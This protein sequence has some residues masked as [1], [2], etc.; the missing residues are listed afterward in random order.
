MTLLITRGRARLDVLVETQNIVGIVFFLD[1]NK[2]SIIRAVGRADKSLA[3]F[4][5]L[6]AVGSLRKGLQL[7]AQ[8]LDPLHRTFFFGWSAPAAHE[9]QFV[10]RLPQ[11]KRS[12]LQTHPRDGTVNRNNEHPGVWKAIVG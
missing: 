11:R 4:A 3:R 6:V 8:G 2:A 9:V 7:V 10:A 1:L 12:V 5:E